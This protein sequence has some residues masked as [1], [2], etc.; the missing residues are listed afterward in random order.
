MRPE[1]GNEADDR[2]SGV[3]EFI[4]APAI[5]C[6]VPPEGRQCD[7]NRDRTLATIDLLVKTLGFE[8]MLTRSC[9]DSLK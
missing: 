4:V 5:S 7:S 1:G 8:R 2:R 9:E 6:K 3:T